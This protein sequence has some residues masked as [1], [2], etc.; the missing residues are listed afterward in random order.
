MVENEKIIKEDIKLPE[1]ILSEIAV[2]TSETL[3]KSISFDFVGVITAVRS[4]ILLPE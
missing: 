4:T 1:N 3:A 2:S